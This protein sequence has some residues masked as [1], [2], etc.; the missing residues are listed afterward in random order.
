MRRY[1]KSFSSVI[2][3]R[4]LELSLKYLLTTNLSV[5]EI[6][7]KIGAVSKPSFCRMFKEK[8]GVTPSEYR[9]IH[10]ENIK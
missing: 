2:N 8:H 1:G 10:R 9:N 6:V 3:E 4:R 5:D 7:H